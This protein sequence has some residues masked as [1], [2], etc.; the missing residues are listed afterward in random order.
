[1]LSDEDQVRIGSGLVHAVEKH[2]H[3]P[4]LK[5]MS[6][7]YDELVA[8]RAGIRK[9]RA[10]RGHDRCWENDLELYKLLPETPPQSPQLPPKPE[11]L[12]ACERYFEEQAH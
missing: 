9:H 1:M 3:I 5:D 10:A 7:I 12:A 6:A 11:F 2:G 8:L 4:M